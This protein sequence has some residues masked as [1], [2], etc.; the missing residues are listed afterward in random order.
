LD[1]FGKPIADLPFGIADYATSVRVHGDQ[2]SPAPR[3]GPALAGKPPAEVLVAAET[4][5]AA[6]GLTATDRVLSTADWDT[7]DAMVDHLLAV[8]AAGASLVQVANR[9]PDAQERRR[10]T[11]KVTRG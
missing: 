8:F 4:A 9:D 10:R 5:G 6:I 3:P 2:V 7:A 1:P 11:E